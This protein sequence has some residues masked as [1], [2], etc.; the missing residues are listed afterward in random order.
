MSTATQ[1]PSPQRPQQ[2]LQRAGEGL[3]LQ[4]RLQ[5]E[6]WNEADRTIEVVWTTGSMVRRYDW[7]E[8]TYYDE[9]LVV[10]P[11]AV[12]LARL[13]NGAAPVLDTHRSG[14]L[15]NVIGVVV[16][17]WLQDGQGYAQLR[18][19]ERP[20]LAGV[21]ADIKAGVIRNISVGYSVLRWEVTPAQ[22]RTDGVPVPLYRAVSWRPSELSFVPIPADA[23]AVS[24]SAHSTPP[25][26][27]SEQVEIV[28]AP[29]HQPVEKSSMEKQDPK[30]GTPSPE[31]TAAQAARAEAEKLERQRGADIINL[32]TRANVPAKAGEY[33]AQGLS[34][35][36][37]RELILDEAF[38][39]DQAAGG[40]RNVHI[41]TVRDET[42]TRRAGV[43]EA[44]LARL[45]S[46]VKLTDN[47]RQYRGMSVLEIVR[48]LAE[49][50]GIK[51]RG[52]AP[53]DL[54]RTAFHTTSDFPII[55]GN[56]ANKRLRS[57]YE[58]NPGTYAIWARRAPD[59][60]D[61]KTITVAQL[62]GAPD[63]QRVNEHGEFQMGTVREAG[64][65]YSLLTAG[66]IVTLTRQAIINDDLRAFDRLVTA[67]GA[68]AVRYENAVVYGILTANAAMADGQPLFSAAAG[69]RAQSNIQTG[70]G[71]AL[72]LAGLNAGRAQMRRMQGFNAEPLNI[73]PSYLIVPAA[74]EHTAY[75]FTSS[76]FVPAQSSNVN[77]FREGG[78]TALTPVVE[79]LLDA[80]SQTQWYLAANSNQ[81][82]TVEYCYLDGAQG[83]VI[84]SEMGF[85]IDG[86]SLKCRL[87][88][89][90]KAIDH[91][92]LHRA[93]GA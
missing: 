75:Q 76:Q 51:T 80:A 46:K 19:S 83:P 47:G 81:V 14:G 48:E 84:E 3:D 4:T 86:M 36:K 55:L 72:A 39:K 9:E 23:D 5:P 44:V 41:E 15:S 89:G 32:C 21:V 88:F 2:H 60:R 67:F 11:E 30:G 33:I 82:D 87:D 93:A 79:P 37:V 92:G 77:E 49:A 34:L 54:A 38:R 20:E 90:A 8:G 61:F 43:E 68:A 50:R 53:M 91:R 56:V 40:N 42:E 74:L 73:T 28:R 22:Q 25:G 63:L 17:A 35:D 70:G 78:R 29:A 12:D 58:E 6:T 45:D 59:A 13:G 52:M 24:R 10:T 57:S 16:R 26:L 27:P 62:S 1:Q 7:Y 71:S 65:T 18:L 31:D 66:R 64:E 69:N 85:E